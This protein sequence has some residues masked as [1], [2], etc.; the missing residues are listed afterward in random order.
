MLNSALQLDPYPH[1]FLP[2]VATPFDCERLRRRLSGSD[3]W[4]VDGDH[5]HTGLKFTGDTRAVLTE[6]AD[7]GP[8]ILGIGRALVERFGSPLSDQVRCGIVRQY[9]GHVTKVH[10]DRPRPGRSTHRAMFYLDSQGVH[11]GGGALNIHT[12]EDEH[13][14]VQKYNA[15]TGSMAAFEASNRSYHSVDQISWGERTAI[16]LYFFHIGNSP[17]RLDQ[18]RQHLELSNDLLSDAEKTSMLA[19]IDNIIRSCVTQDGAAAERLNRSMLEVVALLVSFGVS[20]LSA[21]RQ[22]ID[23]LRK[24]GG[25]ESEDPLLRWSL[26]LSAQTR[27]V[28][29]PTKWHEDMDYLRTSSINNQGLRTLLDRLYPDALEQE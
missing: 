4:E 12:S 2:D 28:F 24:R 13:S 27:T 18:L 10:S 21:K 20:V 22:V 9:T 26:R 15:T 23:M 25:L 11:Y 8:D 6:L 16:L 29:T 7:G 14:V 1:T 17:A 5:L 19:E 3:D